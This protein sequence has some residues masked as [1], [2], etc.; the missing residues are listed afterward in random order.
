MAFSFYRSHV[1]YLGSFNTTLL[2]HTLERRSVALC[3]MIFVLSTYL[4]TIQALIA[5]TSLQ[6]EIRR[7]EW[8]CE[9]PWIIPFIY[10]SSWEPSFIQK[11]STSWINFIWNGGAIRPPTHTP[12]TQSH[13]HKWPTGVETVQ[14]WCQ[15]C[16]LHAVDHLHSVY[17]LSQLH[18]P[19]PCFGRVKFAFSFM[20]VMWFYRLCCSRVNL[21][22]WA[23]QVLLGPVVPL[24]LWV[25]L[26]LMVPLVKL[27]VM[28][29]QHLVCK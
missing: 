13:P 25:A 20:I 2:Q 11:Q 23:S 8:D 6:C 12:Y 21:V 3:R 17:L 22:L 27:V 1:T 4:R 24:V 28:W 5:F 16:F 26:E 29:V 7:E 19:G 9:S 10:D 14:A 15:W 18:F